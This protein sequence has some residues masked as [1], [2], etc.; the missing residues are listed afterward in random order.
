MTLQT[1]EVFGALIREGN[2]LA[3]GLITKLIPC[4]I[5]TLLLHY[6]LGHE[7]SFSFLTSSMVMAVY[8]LSLMTLLKS[9]P[10]SFTLGEAALVVQGLVVFMYH[11]FLT[12]PFLD[13]AK[14]I[15][16]INIVLQI[17]LVGVAVIVASASLI[18]IF[19]K[20]CVF[21]SLLISVIVGV[22]IAPIGNKL[23]VTILINFVFNDT[24][25]IVTVGVYITLLALAGFIVSWQMG[26]NKKGST[27]MRKA[28]HILIVLAF[29]PGL[30][31]QCQ[32]LYVA[33]VVILAIFIVLEVA[34]VIKLFPVAD[35][36]ESSVD[37]F[38]DEKDAGKIALTPIYLLVGCSAPLWIHNSPCDLTGSSSFELLPLLSGILSIG[39]GDTFASIVGSKIGRHKWSS[40][41]KKTV[42][43][44]IA[45]IVA[46]AGFLYSL[47]FLGY[48][49]LTKILM[50]VCGIA[51]IT[52][53]LVEAL[54]DQVD[55]LV[56]P[57]ITFIILAL[58]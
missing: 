35:V 7:F 43:G 19:R 56:L 21:Y 36:L 10:F 18:P 58:K 45:G 27:S 24:E 28:F 2:P 32:F 55:N 22:C 33:T 47:Y 29:L 20:S 48:L 39:I 52:N 17:G 37:A 4:N 11:C 34:R 3:V 44:T 54:T 9:L 15:D 26:K 12:L 16:E 13:E 51:V 8:R 50:A 38:I 46:Q 42:E 57:I 49:P 6:V 14:S 25:R 5:T 30:L 41:S 31:F 1:M 23:A 40:M 53:S